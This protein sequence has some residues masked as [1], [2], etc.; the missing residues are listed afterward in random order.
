MR[1]TMGK[2][3]KATHPYAIWK[4]RDGLWEW[5]VLK[6]WQADDRK[7]FARWF[8]VV[9]SPYTPSGELG[10]CYVQDIKEQATCIYR[11]GE[12]T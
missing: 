12:N 1:N 4:S 2:M 10:D 11:E 6:K 5:R 9:Y 8:C 7:P 3:R